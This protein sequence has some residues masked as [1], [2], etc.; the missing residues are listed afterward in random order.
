MAGMT[1]YLQGRLGCRHVRA[2]GDTDLEAYLDPGENANNDHAVVWRG[3]VHVSQRD[4]C[5]PC[6]TMPF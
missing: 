4:S 3:I 1:G 6:W 5:G 2:G